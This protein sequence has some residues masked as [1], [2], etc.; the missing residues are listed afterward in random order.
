MRHINNDFSMPFTVPFRFYTLQMPA[1]LAR[2]LTDQNRYFYT[3]MVYYILLGH[4]AAAAYRLR[5]CSPIVARLGAD[6]LSMIDRASIA[7]RL[8]SIPNAADGLS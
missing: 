8:R 4:R 2:S 3:A 1:E 7:N 6:L 5:A